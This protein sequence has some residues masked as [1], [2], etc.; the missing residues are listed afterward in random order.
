MAGVRSRNGDS[1]GRISVREVAERAGVAISSVSRVLSGHKDVSEPMRKRVLEAVAQLGYEPDFLAQSLR[2]GSTRTI[3]FVVGDITNPVM[4]SCVYGAEAVLRDAGYSILL[5]DSGGD[6]SLDEEHI[7]LL[8][9]R[10]VDGMILSLASE[11]RRGTLQLLSQLDVPIVLLDREVPAGLAVNAVYSDHRSGTRAA[12]EHLLDLGHRRVALITASLD[13]RA[14]R[15]RVA[16]MKDAIAARGIPDE[17]IALP[18]SLQAEHGESSTEELLASDNPPTAIIAGG[19]QILVGTLRALSRRRIRVGRDV[20]LV[21]CDE[22]PVT[23][24]YEPRIATISRD[25]VAMGRAAAQL[26]Q[27]RLRQTEAPATVTLPTAFEARPS[28]CPPPRP[29]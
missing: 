3:G 28:A 6:A 23:E 21:A 29:H 9:S 22:S 8:R 13:M 19:N 25:L 1:G 2:R 10:R 16:G 17:T 20:A 26:L 27:P 12:V 11:K 5:M 18:S 14:G 4:A 15:E 24:F 7:R